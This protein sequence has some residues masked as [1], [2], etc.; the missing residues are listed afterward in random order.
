MP[1][2]ARSSRPEEKILDLA[3]ELAQTR[4]FN[5]FS[6]ADIAP[7]LGVTKASLHYHFPSKADLGK[8]LVRRYRRDFEHALEAIVAGSAKAPARLLRYLELYDA[9]MR[10][11]RMCLCG[12]F[13]AE[14]A[15][16]P[17]PMQDELRA[18]FEMNERWL[19]AVLDA[20]RRAGELDFRSSPA[21]RAAMLLGALEGLMLVARVRNDEGGFRT[22]ARRVL[23]D[24]NAG[25]RSA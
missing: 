3:E 12:M 7:R 23:A 11:G 15:T 9:V 2:R 20:G 14:Y 8:A 16:L 10:N 22:A 13:A 4:G 17:P 5:G 21:R 25:T 24:L 18:F 19:A 1:E 6:Y